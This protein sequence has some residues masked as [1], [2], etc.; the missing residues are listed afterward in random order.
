MPHRSRW[1]EIAALALFMLSLVLPA[2]VVTDKPLFGGAADAEVK[3][4]PGIVCLLYGWVVVPGW[5]ANPL[6][7]IGGI[8][9]AFGKHRAALVLSIIA[10]VSAL[11]AP[12]W[13]SGGIMPLRYPHVGY[14][15]W[16][17]SI[18]A[19]VIAAVRGLRG[20]RPF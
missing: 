18:L 15:V 16:V 20:S 17:A 6:V 2:V 9:Q 11:T 5:I 1:L 19:L 3:T 8:L 4:L 12:L 10:L 14:Y 7:I 13:M